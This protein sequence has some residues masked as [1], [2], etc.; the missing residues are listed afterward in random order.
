MPKYS[1]VV[2]DAYGKKTKGQAAAVD[3]I[4]LSEQLFKDGMYM[5]SCK[6][7]TKEVKRKALKPKELSEFCRQMGT[8]VASGVTL[9]RALVS[10]RRKKASSPIKSTSTGN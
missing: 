8:L 9:V 6:E 3:E 10:C 4:E 2:R 7:L 5:L 1:Y